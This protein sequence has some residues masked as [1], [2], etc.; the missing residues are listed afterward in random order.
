MAQQTIIFFK[1]SIWKNLKLLNFESTFLGHVCQH[2]FPFPSLF[3]LWVIFHLFSFLLPLLPSFFPSFFPSLRIVFIW[4]NQ[5]QVCR[6]SNKTSK[7]KTAS[8]Q[9]AL[10]DDHQRDKTQNHFLWVS[11][12]IWPN[13]SLL[14]GIELYLNSQTP[15]GHLATWTS[16]EPVIF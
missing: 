6:E 1:K 2:P 14:S 13:K 15:L 9:F 4:C 3:P 10:H 8:C 16:L 7:Q 5:T 11:W 12:W